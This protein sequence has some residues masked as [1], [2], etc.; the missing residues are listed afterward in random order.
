M[1]LSLLLPTKDRVPRLTNFLNSVVATA[2]NLNEVEV[3]LLVDDDDQ[4]TIDFD[5][6]DKSLNLT[7]LVRPHASMGRANHSCMENAQG[8]IIMLVNDDIIVREQGWDSKI[9]KAAEQFSDG[10]FLLYPNDLFKGEKL[11]VFPILSKKFCELVK[12]PFPLCFQGAFIDTHLSDIFQRLK[13]KGHNRVVYLPDVVFEHMHY[14]LGKGSKDKTYTDRKRFG[15]DQQFLLLNTYREELATAL[16][17]KI[18]QPEN[19]QLTMPE[20]SYSDTPKEHGL[21]LYIKRTFL[22]NT[23]PLK[24]RLQLGTYYTLRYLYSAMQDLKSRKR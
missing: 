23:L 15:D 9:I 3:I 4:A 2:D 20:L 5:Y 22:D 16:A 21:G 10:I 17:K 18:E 8:K 11:S 14:R 6:E 12:E 13:G 24:K 19:E 7:K 1:Q